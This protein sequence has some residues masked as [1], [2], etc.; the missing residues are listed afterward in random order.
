VG[1]AV[2]RSQA[3]AVGEVDAPTL[4]S[5]GVSVCQDRPLPLVV[6]RAPWPHLLRSSD[7]LPLLSTLYSCFASGFR[8]VFEWFTDALVGHWRRWRCKI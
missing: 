5:R 6:T 1:A 8:V 7:P 3:A 4:G 2:T